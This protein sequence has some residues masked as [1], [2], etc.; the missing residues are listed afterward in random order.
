MSECHVHA[1]I[2]PEDITRWHDE[3]PD[4]KLLVHPECGCASQAMAFGDERTRILSTEGMVDFAKKSPKDRFVVATEVGIIHR[5]AK[6]APGKRFEPA[7]P[8]ASCRF[9]KMITLAKVRDSLRDDKHVV[10]VPAGVASRARGAIERMV[11][12]S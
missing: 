3:A 7:N 8:S 5:L 11:A 9:M 6:E 12:I 4:S 10:E 1:G 2:R